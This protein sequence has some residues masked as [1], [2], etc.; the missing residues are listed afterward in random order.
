MIASPQMCRVWLDHFWYTVMT[1]VVERPS[2]PGL[3]VPGTKVK[4]AIL[5]GNA[6]N[7]QQGSL[8]KLTERRLVPTILIGQTASSTAHEGSPFREDLKSSD[9]ISLRVY[10][11]SK[12]PN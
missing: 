2:T 7:L 4:V 11:T 12:K 8:R 5:Y 9:L 3:K 1:D 10:N 6:N